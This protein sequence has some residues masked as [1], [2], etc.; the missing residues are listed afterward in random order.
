M[1]RRKIRVE[2][3]GELGVLDAFIQIAEDLADAGQVVSRSGVVRVGLQGSL[4]R[5]PSALPVAALHERFDLR[6]GADRRQREH[7]QK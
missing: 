4:S 6:I 3:H 1:R 5:R 2:F 7:D